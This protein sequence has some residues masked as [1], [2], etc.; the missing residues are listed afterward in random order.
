MTPHT[1]D[2]LTAADLPALVAELTRLRLATAHMAVYGRA[3]LEAVEGG[4]L[5]LAHTGYPAYQAN[6]ALHALADY[7]AR[8]MAGEW[9]PLTQEIVGQAW[10][11]HAKRPLWGEEYMTRERYQAALHDLL[12]HPERQFHAVNTPPDLPITGTVGTALEP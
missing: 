10:D 12:W 3:V 9:H 1:L 11:R 6:H 2:D 4:G 8:T 5:T 7:I